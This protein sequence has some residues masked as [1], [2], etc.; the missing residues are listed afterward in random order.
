VS[1]PQPAPGLLPALDAQ[2]G[3]LLGR[4]RTANSCQTYAGLE[5]GLHL[6][7]DRQVMCHCLP[8][9]ANEAPKD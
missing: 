3:I 7:Y 5:V 1:P 2:G 9:D 4:E 6:K 8:G